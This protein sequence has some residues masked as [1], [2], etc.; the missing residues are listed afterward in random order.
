MRPAI[1]RSINPIGRAFRRDE[2]GSIA[3]I[4][5]LTSL[6]VVMVTGLAI[7]VGRVMHANSALSEALDSAAL[8]AAKGMQASNL[9]DAE[10]E[11]VARRYFEV[12]M[13][14]HGGNYAV[15]RTFTA[16]VDRARGSVTLDARAE[17]PTTFANV[18]GVSSFAVPKSSVAMFD[19]KDL[20][21]GIQLDLTGSMCQ[22]CSK[23]AALKDA[24][25]G[26]GGLLDI[27]LP[28]GGTTN[29]VRIGLAPFSAGVN[30]G[31]YASAV[32]GGRAGRDGCTYERRDLSLQDSESAPLGSFALK[33]KSDLPGAAACP[34]S[35]RVT[36][37]TGDKASLR[38]EIRG[39]GTGNSTAGHLGAAW[40]WHLVSPEWAGIWG[41][42]APADYNDKR[43][44]K[45]VILMTDGIYNT[46]GGASDGDY[47]ST[48][49]RSQDFAQ[50]TCQAMKAKGV[51]VFTI[52]FTAP[53]AAKVGLQSCASN[54]SKFY[55]AN[56]G[57]ML[58]AAFKAI[59]AEI[60]NL[61]LSS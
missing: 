29:S 3:I 13:Q 19:S 2:L 14:G 20:E 55:D 5:G 34:S 15:V 43:T 16:T 58:K 32:T 60:S 10:V 57:D 33:A 45:Y 51:V 48:A 9:T 23:I 41:G 42:K 39:W 46:V 61:R 52:G 59:A 28:D 56:D 8:A 38:S 21:V 47:G 37:M 44:Q 31:S 18:A 4:F 35:A 30:A 53:A 49:T 27:L 40:A 36:A 11:D 7:D 6:V 12:N 22:P 25:A 24:V 1:A 17:V 50:S 54:S 26:P